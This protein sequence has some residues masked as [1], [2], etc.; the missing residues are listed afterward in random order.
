MQ[1]T[2]ATGRPPFRT[3]CKNKLRQEDWQPNWVADGRR[4]SFIGPDNESGWQQQT[5]FGLD[6]H[7]QV[8]AGHTILLEQSVNSF[9]SILL[10][11]LGQHACY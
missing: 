8:S 2:G 5:K 9:D 4:P 7:L 10:D 3:D 1:A 11:Q 6:F